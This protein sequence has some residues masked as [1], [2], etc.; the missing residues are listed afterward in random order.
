[1][2]RCGLVGAT[3]SAAGAPRRGGTRQASGA[4]EAEHAPWPL[5]RAELVRLDQDL[6]TAVGLP[7]P[8]GAPLVHASPGVPVRIGLW[9]PRRPSRSLPSRSRLGCP[10]GS[11]AFE[12]RN[13]VDRFRQPASG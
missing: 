4:A 11:G 1:M 9:Y 7:A 5:H 10:T 8:T 6:V 2:P 13:L 3:A 12:S